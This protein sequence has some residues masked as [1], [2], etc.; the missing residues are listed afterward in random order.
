M[1]RNSS[2]LYYNTVSPLLIKVLKQLMKLPEFAPFRLVGGTSLSLQRGHRM[3]I[4][5]DLFTDAVYGTIDFSKITR[6]LN[7]LYP[8]VDAIDIE[9]V[10]FGKS[11]FIG[12]NEHNCVKLDVYYT[13]AFI[14]EPIVIEGIRMASNEEII[15]M[16]LDVI[17]RGGRKK[18]FWDIHEMMKDYSFAKMLSLHEQR[19]P[20]THDKEIIRLNFTNFKEADDDFEPICLHHK[21]WEV[22]KLDLIDFVK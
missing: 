18:D 2:K 16:K 21:Y 10:G 19:Y 13:D 14:Q 20:F 7:K 4:D 12:E 6:S 3:S 17:L 8:Y 11:Y 9:V 15:A 1:N 22:I 5:I